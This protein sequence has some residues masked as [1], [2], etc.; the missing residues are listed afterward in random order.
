VLLVTIGL[1][2]VVG[3]LYASGIVIRADNS[4]DRI[5]FSLPA[6]LYAIVASLLFS[7]RYLRNQRERMNLAASA[8]ELRNALQGLRRRGG[9]QLTPVPAELLE[10]TAIIESAQ[11]ASERKDA[12]LQ[13]AAF[14]P[15][16]YAITF[17]RSATEQRAML[18]TVDRIE[19]EDV[20]AELST[21][22][23]RLE[24]QAET[25]TDAAGITLR[26]TTRS[27]H[28][29]ID[30]VIDPASRGIQI[31]ALRHR[32]LASPPPLNGAGNV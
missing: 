30:C 2:I 25:V 29:E 6:L 3:M 9:T 23:D 21:N 20:V 11:I 17:S 8:D 16:A 4:E 24:A 1:L 13:S 19:L 32:D 18:S 7:A 14:R 26:S 15:K 27:E 22:G 5:S 10:K 12:V 31:V 28:V